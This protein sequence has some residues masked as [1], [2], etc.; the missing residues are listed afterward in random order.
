METNPSFCQITPRKNCYKTWKT[1]ES[2]NAVIPSNSRPVPQIRQWQAPGRPMPPCINGT[3]QSIESFYNLQNSTDTQ[4]NLNNYIADGEWSPSFISRRSIHRASKHVNKKGETVWYSARPNPIKHWRK[5]LFPR[6]GYTVS[7]ARATISQTMESPGGTIN[8]ISQDICFNIFKTEGFCP[9]H[10][11]VY[12]DRFLPENICEK[13]CSKNNVSIP[14]IRTKTNFTRYYHRTSSAYLQSRVKLY[15]QRAAIQF[16]RNK[17]PLNPSP[18]LSN[19]S[20]QF[21]SLYRQD[22][23]GCFTPLDCSCIV[24]VIYK[25]S[26]EVFAKQHAVT[27]SLY[28]K[29]IKQ[30]TINQNQYNITNTWGL[31]GTNTNKIYPLLQFK[32]QGYMRLARHGS[33]V[34]SLITCGSCPNLPGSSSTPVPL[35]EGFT[36][37]MDNEAHTKMVSI[38]GSQ[39]ATIPVKPNSM[40]FQ[41]FPSYNGTTKTRVVVQYVDDVGGADAK[42]SGFTMNIILTT[43]NHLGSDMSYNIEIIDWD[44]I[45]FIQ[46]GYNFM[47]DGGPEWTGTMENAIGTPK[48]LNNTSLERSFD[49]SASGSSPEPNH[50]PNKNFGNISTWDVSGVIN[51]SYTF[52][53]CIYINKD[54]GDWNVSNVQTFE[55][56]FAAC[57]DF[58]GANLSKWDTSSAKD[59]QYMFYDCQNFNTDLSGWD[60]SNVITMNDMFNGSINFLGTGL[61]NWDTSSVEDMQ[62][63]FYDCQ[64]F[65]GDLTGWTTSKVTTMSDMFNGCTIF[66]GTGLQ[67]WDTSAVSIMSSMFSDCSNFNVD[68]GNWNISTVTDICGMFYNATNFNQD[69]SGW[70]ITELQAGN[71]GQLSSAAENM[72]DDS[73]MSTWNVTQLLLGWANTIKNNGNIPQY[74]ILGLNNMSYYTVYEPAVLDLSNIQNWDLSGLDICNNVPFLASIAALTDWNNMFQNGVANSALYPDLSGIILQTNSNF[75]LWDTSNVTNFSRMFQNCATFAGNG[76][77]NWDTSSVTRMVQMFQNCTTFTGNGLDNW[78]TSSVNDMNQMFSGASN[79]NQDISGW[80]TSSA[81]SMVQMFKNASTFN[82]NINN[83]ITSSVND[84]NQMFSGASN[85]D[86]NISSWDTSSVTNMT[87]MFNEASNFNQ[88][89]SSWNTGSVTNMTLMFNKATKFDQKLDIWNTSGVTDMFSMFK[90]AFDTSMNGIWTGGL[91]NFKTGLD[92]IYSNSGPVGS[93][94]SNGD[95]YMGPGDLGQ[96]PQI[97]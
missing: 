62:Y 73:G 84:M 97:N 46:K 93:F 50:M 1:H 16:Q 2:K 43:L 6:Q 77:E 66:S 45:P 26:N 41:V 9:L 59:M 36:Y 86:Q 64:N 96:Y 4:I 76:F 11:P 30:A 25:P 12:I 17:A 35:T 57:I 87:Q 82:Q 14:I 47:C 81:T 56:M 68:L 5:Q 31:D 89:I 39:E 75:S 67:L 60:T 74:I 21:A 48:L 53:Y 23:S 85:F 37:E 3:C 52:F 72:L 40:T 88:D 8:N 42:N 70:D 51:M 32:T 22:V 83:W 65:D 19:S 34:G 95:D 91:P 90:D 92:T 13:D 10:I 29:N 27:G 69:I 33:G 71:S 55:G 38:M 18:P 61:Q 7:K 15:R 78:D 24:Q 20:S 54:L 44:N 58:S 63:M 49:Y 80:D 94:F 28:T 79:F